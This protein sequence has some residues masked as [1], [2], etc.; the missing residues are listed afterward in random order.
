MWVWM[1][2][3]QLHPE[4]ENRISYFEVSWWVGRKRRKTIR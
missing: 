1:V 2:W 3:W 4:N